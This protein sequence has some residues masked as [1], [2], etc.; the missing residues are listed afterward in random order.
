[1]TQAREPD[2]KCRRRPAEKKLSA[3]AKTSAQAGSKRRLEHFFVLK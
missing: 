2:E 3:A 1:M